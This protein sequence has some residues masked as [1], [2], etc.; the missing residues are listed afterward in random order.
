MG[1]GR[2]RAFRRDDIPD[3]VALRQ[4]VFRFSERRSAGVLGAYFE[5]IFF[6]HPW[7]DE[8]L[9]SWVH[10]DASGRVTGFLGVMPRRMLWRGQAIRTAVATQL[11]V[12]PQSRGLVGRWL[13]R[14]FLAG[15][16]DCSLSDTANDAARRIWESL[17]AGT[18]MIHSLVWLR[19]LRPCRDLTSRLAHGL[20]AR[21][22]LYAARPLVAAGDA[23]AARRAG[24]A[25][26]KPAG[27]I[28]PLTPALM[29]AHLDVLGGR[30]LRPAYEA[31]AL[32]WLLEQAAEKRQF[33]TLERALVRD[34][35]GE[36]AGWFL[37]FLNPGG[38]SQVVQLAARP[39]AQALVLQ[40]LFHHAWSRG[41]VT[42]AGRLEPALVPDLAT[43]G[44]GFRRDGP[45]VLIHSRRPEL[46]PAVER[47]DAF[48]SRLEGEWWLS[49]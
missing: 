16:Q 10:E 30:A 34:P 20:A 31:G 11:M 40:H 47:G 32:D 42:V 28:Q 25:A 35:S 29:L 13:V 7:P 49:F 38:A 12:E 24:G 14:A 48:L 33:G 44:C 46:M 36:V 17:G 9:P 19:P 22:A 8:E 5:R 26:R 15:P 18:S 4:Q 41:A 27:T 39:A 23:F 37:Y 2:L 1:S 45:W 21:G 3:V 43:L 6:H